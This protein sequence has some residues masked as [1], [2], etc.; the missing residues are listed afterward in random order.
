MTTSSALSTVPSLTCIYTTHLYTWVNAYLV[1]R[2]PKYADYAGLLVCG[3]ISC[4]LMYQGL[5]AFIVQVIFF[6]VTS[7]SL[8]QINWYIIKP[9]ALFFYPV[10]VAEKKLTACLR[11]CLVFSRKISCADLIPRMIC[12]VSLYK[13]ILRQWAL[14]NLCIIKIL[15]EGLRNFGRVTTASSFY[16]PVSIAL[17]AVRTIS[18]NREVQYPLQ[19]H[20]GIPLVLGK[21]DSLLCEELMLIT[22]KKGKQFYSVLGTE[23]ETS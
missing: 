10:S 1:Q 4:T 11:Q 21:L 17:K 2:R 16:S 20:W 18:I 6:F 19:N 15:S 5:Y 3:L 13:I 14:S 9:P 8:L 7:G 23:K 12:E 22:G